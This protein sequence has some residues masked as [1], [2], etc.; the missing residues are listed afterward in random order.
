MSSDAG[1]MWGQIIILAVLILLNACF[2]AAET[3]SS[4]NKGRVKTL[5][6]EG[7]RKAAVLSKFIRYPTSRLPQCRW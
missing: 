7:N 4:V 5:A 3:I 2:A 1:P 6:Q